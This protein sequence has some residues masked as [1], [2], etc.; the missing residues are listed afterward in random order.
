LPV[1]RKEVNT[2]NLKEVRRMSSAMSPSCLLN[3]HGE[4]KQGQTNSSSSP[5]PEGQTINVG[6][7]QLGSS[8]SIAEYGRRCPAIG[9]HTDRPD[10]DVSREIELRDER[11]W[12]FTVSWTGPRGQGS[13]AFNSN[14]R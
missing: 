2:E 10:W 14:V 5:G 3:Q 1:W 7:V 13:T 12:H 6:D 8:I 11:A 4:L 9:D